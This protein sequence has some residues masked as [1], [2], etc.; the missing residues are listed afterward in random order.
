[1]VANSVC[2]SEFACRMQW[3]IALRGK[4]GL[5]VLRTNMCD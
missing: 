3:E 4:I 5:C 2:D 1:M